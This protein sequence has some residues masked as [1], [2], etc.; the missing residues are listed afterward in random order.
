MTAGQQCNVFFGSGL[1]DRSCSF[2]TTQSG[3]ARID[4]NGNGTYVLAGTA[5]TC[6]I[7]RDSHN[8]APA[9]SN[10]ETHAFTWWRRKHLGTRIS[11]RLEQHDPGFD[12]SGVPDRPEKYKRRGNFRRQYGIT[13]V[14][15]TMTLHGILPTRANGSRG[16]LMRSVATSRFKKPGRVRLG[17]HRCHRAASMV[18][19]YQGASS[20][21]IFS[22]TTTTRLC[23]GDGIN[24]IA[25]LDPRHSD[26]PPP[27]GMVWWRCAKCSTVIAPTPDENRFDRVP[28]CRC[29]SGASTPRPSIRPRTVFSRRRGRHIYRWNSPTNSLSKPVTLTEGFGELTC[30]HHWPG[31][32]V[33]TA[34]PAA[35]SLRSAA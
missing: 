11:P 28:L 27:S 13:M 32:V 1:G 10:D 34:Q 18:P 33:Y 15:L 24:K 9:L 25:L 4:S 26:R 17:L 29:A 16:F 22:N 23:D 30:L 14:G 2:K 12:A 8:S 21:L 5:P 3:F 31:G 19:S 6:T 7:N 35:P 20:Y